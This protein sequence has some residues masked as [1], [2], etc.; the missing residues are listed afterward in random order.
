MPA[1]PLDPDHRPA[2]GRGHASGLA[3]LAFRALLRLCPQTFRARY[4]TEIEVAFRD[5]RAEDRYQGPTGAL[6]F[7]TDVI[8]DCC[9]ASVRLR[10][11]P[12]RAPA[13]Q[14]YPA[15]R[16]RSAL[17]MWRDDLRSALRVF[18]HRPGLA[19]VA[20]ISLGLGLGGNGL[21]F[22][23]VDNL[24]LRPFPFPDPDRLVAVGVTFPR[25]AA[26]ERFIEALS[27]AE[28][29]DIRGIGALQRVSA[30]DL[31]NRN[32]SGGDRPE[33]VF[34]ALVW[35]DPFATLGMPPLHGR[36]FTP[37]EMR[38]GGPRAAIISHR[39]WL[40]RFGGD[41]A[42]VGRTIR[43]NGEETTLVGIMPPGLLLVGTDMWTPLVADPSEWPR[44]RRQ[45][46][47]IGR[48]APG[49]SLT[50]ANAALAGLA[51]RTASDHATTFK[52]YRDWR[53]AAVPLH[54][55][56]TRAQRPAGLLL[57]ATAAVVLLIMCVNL[58]NV[59]LA[60]ANARQRDLAIRVALG[61]SRTAI[62]R[63]LV[64]ETL[65]LA[66]A[67][68]AAGIVLAWIGL[69]A[70][71]ALIPANLKTLG[72]DVGMDGRVV[73][74]TT[75]MA[76]LAGL[77][78]G[79]VPG[80]KGSLTRPEATLRDHAGSVAPKRSLFLRH[81]LI[82]TEVALATMLLVGAGLL[83]RSFIRLQ[84]VDPGFTRD[85]V[86]T[87]RLTLPPQ[88]YQ[89][90]AVG[91]FFDDLV[92][93]VRALPGVSASAAASQFPPQINFSSRLRVEGAGG[94]GEGELPS[95][96]FTLVTA[97]FF[98]TLGVRLR[99]G[100]LLEERDRRGAPPVVVVNEAFMR[101]YLGGASPLGRRIALAGT[102]P[103]AWREVVGVVADIRSQ[104]LAV[105][106]GPQIYLP[107]TQLG[108]AWNQLF[109]LI[110][111]AGEPRSVLPMVRDAVR[112]LDPEQP[113]YG[114]QTLDEV[115]DAVLLQPRVSTWLMGAFAA[116]ALAIAAVGLY[117]VLSFAVT[118][119][120]REIG[121]R[122]AL[123]AD[124]T[125]VVGRVVGDAAVLAMVGAAIGLAGSLALGG[126][127][128][129]L[130]ND[131]TPRDPATL[132]VVSTLLLATAVAAALVPARR[133]SRIDPVLALRSE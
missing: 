126:L 62:F 94:E 9:V 22:G 100:R 123:G 32:I 124:R 88:K 56:L 61:A 90:E 27:P 7:W 85:R 16:S 49:A 5:Q 45:F 14:P 133:A 78:I 113:V 67:G 120:T 74:Y 73:L 107:N 127:M 69:G 102:G 122:M 96:N 92:A 70:A 105:P 40:S 13:R 97:G 52:E 44:D 87:M 46:T 59:W 43:V 111:T 63:S 24:V 21:M 19:A 4:G 119:R 99:T 95:A 29:L 112:Q 83:L 118:S 33:R 26:E 53:L 93:R 36:G 109:L 82:V 57:L 35:G 58:A 39:I 115:F 48:L 31:G 104:G 108:D 98:D 68:V 60:Q 50:Q 15:R 66:I 71:R 79:I 117:G 65:V 86:L 132:A 116:L 80:V 8:R 2:R 6:R 23:L 129:R 47:V 77:A 130:L 34:N 110:R 55:A 84:A 41:P 54:H 125:R 64:V 18:K 89:G 75:M 91:A 11:H 101:R 121:I 106:A 103:A 30:F 17:D 12:R 1:P 81:G 25:L 76:T 20:V 72:L 128:S 28:Y 10:A 114:I 131:V 51:G 42:I 37:D 38:R 3:T